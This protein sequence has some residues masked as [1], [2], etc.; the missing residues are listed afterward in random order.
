[1]D[2]FIYDKDL[3]QERVKFPADFY[4]NFFK[5]LRKNLLKVNTEDSSTIYIE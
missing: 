3:R 4:A 2:W 1:M 5:L